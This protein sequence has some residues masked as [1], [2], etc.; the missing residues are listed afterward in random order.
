MSHRLSKMNEP[1]GQVDVSMDGGSRTDVGTTDVL[2]PVKKST[3][4]MNQLL[5]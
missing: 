5:R 3:D 4:R 1:A 2:L